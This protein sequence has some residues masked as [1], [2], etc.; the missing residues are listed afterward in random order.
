MSLKVRFFKLNRWR[1]VCANH[2]DAHHRMYK[3]SQYFLHCTHD[4]V[5]VKG[6]QVDVHYAM[7]T[8]CPLCRASFSIDSREGGGYCVR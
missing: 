5:K 8:L 4:L 3:L 2:V 1:A 7:Q 6:T